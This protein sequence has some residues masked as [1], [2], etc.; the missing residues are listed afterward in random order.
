MNFGDD[1]DEGEK[2]LVGLR[3]AAPQATREGAFNF[4]RPEAAV[5]CFVAARELVAFS[6]ACRQ[7]SS[8]NSHEP[9]NSAQFHSNVPMLELTKAK[10]LF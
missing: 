1:E 2:R 8:M 3:R 7:I 5:G 4:V 9:F 10:G 6:L